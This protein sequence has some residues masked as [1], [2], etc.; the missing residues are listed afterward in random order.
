MAQQRIR[1]YSDD[2]NYNKISSRPPY[3]RRDYN[4]D[5]RYSNDPKGYPRRNTPSYI[6]ENQTQTNGFAKEGYGIA[7]QKDK[8][9]RSFDDSPQRHGPYDRPSVR[10]EQNMQPPFMKDPIGPV[11]Q[12]EYPN[13]KFLSPTISNTPSSFRSRSNRSSDSTTSGSVFET[14][15]TVSSYVEGEKSTTGA[16]EKT[17]QSEIDV[18]II[19]GKE[20]QKPTQSYKWDAFRLMPVSDADDDQQCLESMKKAA[21][22]ISYI[23]VFIMV[24]GTTFLSKFTLV[25]LAANSRFGIKLDCSNTSLHEC[26]VALDDTSV[27]SKRFLLINK[28]VIEATMPTSIPSN[29]TSNDTTPMATDVVY[30]ESNLVSGVVRQCDT[31][32]MY[33]VWGLVMTVCI[34]YILV[35]WR[36]L[37]RM[38]FKTKQGPS[39]ITFV[40]VMLVETLHSIGIVLLVFYIIR[41]LDSVSAIAMLTSVGTIPSALSLFYRPLVQRA[42]MAKRGLNITATFIHVVGI[43]AWPVLIF[44]KTTTLTHVWTIPLSLLLISCGWWETFV[45]VRYTY[46]GKLGELLVSV[47]KNARRSRSKLYAVVSIWKILLTIC[48]MMVTM[49]FD[50]RD[51]AG[52]GFNEWFFFPNHENKCPGIANGGEE[53][54]SNDIPDIIWIWAVIWTIQFLSSS[55]SYIFAKFGAKTLIQ[56]IAVA[57]PLLL[58]TPLTICIMVL[59][60]EPNQ[61]AALA[62]VLPN[63]VFWQCTSWSFD[64]P[65]TY[66]FIPLAIICWL[67]QLWVTRHVWYPATQRLAKTEKLFALPLFCGVMIEQSLSFNR[68]K[69]DHIIS[70]QQEKKALEVILEAVGQEV[71]DAVGDEE[72]TRMTYD[73]IKA[74]EDAT[75]MIYFCATMWHE[76][77]QEMIHLLNSIFKM[78]IDQ[79]AR[80]N[81]QA[82]FGI[83]DPD[84]YNFET[85]IFFD[86]AFDFHIDG[87][88]DYEANEFVKLLVATIDMSASAVHR[89]KCKIA[90]PVKCETP[91]G[92]MLEWHLPGGN[93]LIAHLKDKLKIRHKKRWSQVMYMYMFL[94]HKLWTK[95]K[96]GI[97]KQNVAENT[98]LLALDGDVD[99]Q[100]LSVLLLVDLMKRNEK[101]G[102]AC[103]RIH[104]IGAGPMVWYQKFEYA[105]GHW[106]QKSTEHILGCVLCSPGCFSL[107][108][109]AALM[110]DNIVKRYT[111]VSTDPVHYVQYDQGEDR[112]LCTLLLQQGYRVEYSAASDAFTFAPEGFNE[113]FNQRRRW[114]PSTMANI[115]DLIISANQTTKTNENISWLYIAYQTALFVSSIIGPATVFLVI[116]GSLE[117]LLQMG[118]NGLW[119]AFTVNLVLIIMFVVVGLKAKTDTQL[120]VAGVLS[121]LYALVMILVMVSV[122]VNFRE[123]YLCDPSSLFTVVLVGMFLLTGILHPQEISCL[124]HGL[125]YYLAV[126]STFMLLTIFS[127]CNL[128]NVSWGTREVKKTKT[129]QELLDAKKE[130]H[131]AKQKGVSGGIAAVV[132]AVTQEGINCCGIFRCLPGNAQP[133][134]VSPVVVQPSYPINNQGAS[135][136]ETNIDDLLDVA[137]EKSKLSNNLPDL[138]SNIPEVRTKQRSSW[139][140]D[141]ALGDGK[142]IRISKSDKLFS[143]QLIERYLKP[144]ENDKV[145]QEKVA[146]GLKD[147]RNKVVFGFVVM[148]VIYIT[149][150]QSL[151]LQRERALAFQIDVCPF[152]LHPETGETI[153][154]SIQPMAMVFLLFFGI[155][156]GVQFVGMLAH[157]MET[158]MHVIATTYLACFGSKQKHENE[159]RERIKKALQTAKD[160][161]ALK[162]EDSSKYSTLTSIADDIQS[163]P[164][165]P[166][167]LQKPKGVDSNA[168]RLD[169]AQTRRP[170]FGTL[171][172]AFA[173]RFRRVQKHIEN[174]EEPLPDYGANDDNPVPPKNKMRR[175]IAKDFIYENREQ[176]LNTNI[177][178]RQD[179][180]PM[181]R[182]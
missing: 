156:L 67:G 167:P 8:R 90:A 15:D 147:L 113:F 126:P 62:G 13:S 97:K 174:G 125:L 72:E 64:E 152:H 46:M 52:L 18:E 141:P 168:T 100:P 5:S 161:S 109:G 85:H 99:F 34:P 115:L 39:A 12:N 98:F 132:P 123:K 133:V 160:L 114:T 92:G 143:E 137:P 37:W 75:P 105:V 32:T 149:V 86:D 54:G 68:R 93:K 94:G 2:R 144:L 3:I 153:E 179:R 106:F 1:N 9:Y 84:F 122:I 50:M 104:P 176:I 44:Y 180:N 4:P 140:R 53:V 70:D 121:T 146:M 30:T 145:H 163:V 60:C 130:A 41:K 175:R 47:K 36:S 28:Q 127:V 159:N 88:T 71:D 162:S 35:L 129:E 21:K 124:A 77:E 10:D 69:D 56:D 181:Y 51:S 148:N 108:R 131:E 6:G 138:T 20:K 81:A 73:T 142:I 24:L 95:V 65:T 11:Q 171:D 164:K 150:V 80:K 89:M 29:T 120:F 102:A 25:V 79:N 166:N 74:K 17:N 19:D 78:D 43:I 165:Q 182:Y 135:Q 63:H 111:T 169:P 151:Q 82:Y 116:V 38:C 103:G 16:Q 128:N 57:L 154:L 45:H 83:V 42:A 49:N 178:N 91:Y 110:D 134:P 55:F 7:N 61:R 139:I 107:F 119:I 101:V 27:G 112:W 96:S 48:G 136:D 26:H 23:F 33:W 14:S 66:L 59:G 22:I 157:R 40:V 177:Y 158:F 170:S 76:N 155:V 58:S 173:R 87:D 31:M 117:N 118:D 172:A